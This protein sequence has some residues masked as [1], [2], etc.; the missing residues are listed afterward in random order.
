MSSG[1]SGTGLYTK[2]KN[3]LVTTIDLG[4]L[5][6]ATRRIVNKIKFALNLCILQLC[7]TL[8]QSN[9]QV[10]WINKKWFTKHKTLRLMFSHNN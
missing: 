2:I 3:K 1:K 4:M 6:L 7:I 5:F 8:G 10:D 9:L